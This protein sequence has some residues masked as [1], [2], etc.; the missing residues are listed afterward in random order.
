M[1]P[2]PL[3]DGE[4]AIISKADRAQFVDLMQVR[5]LKF[6]KFIRGELTATNSPDEVWI[7]SSGHPSALL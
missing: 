7:A 5:L 1:V 2:F 3:F 4:I 6:W